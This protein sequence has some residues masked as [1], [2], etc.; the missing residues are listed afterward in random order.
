MKTPITVSSAA[1]LALLAFASTVDARSV[2]GSSM[3]SSSV[4]RGNIHSSASSLGSSN[5]PKHMRKFNDDGQNDPP[6]K[7]TPQGGSTDGSS[8]S[9]YDS[10][11]K[12]G[13]YSRYGYHPHPHPIDP[14]LACKGR[15]C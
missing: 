12:F 9:R 7:K 1:M 8:G 10:G 2:G 14:P 6:P 13:D 3:S 15:P 4:S 11:P 5:G